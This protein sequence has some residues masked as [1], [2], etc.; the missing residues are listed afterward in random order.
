VR[1]Y[2]EMM[3]SLERGSLHRST[4][5]TLMNEKSSRSHAIFTIYIEQHQITEQSNVEN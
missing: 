5:S 2:D 3:K 4:S 1:T